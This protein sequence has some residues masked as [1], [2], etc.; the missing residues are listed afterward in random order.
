M[1]EPI[2]GKLLVKAARSLAFFEI[3]GGPSLELLWPKVHVVMGFEAMAF[4]R[5]RVVYSDRLN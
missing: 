5:R 3:G 2:I 4:D 1:V